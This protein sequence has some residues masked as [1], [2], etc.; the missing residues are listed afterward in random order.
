MDE[1]LLNDASRCREEDH[2][3]EE[4]RKSSRKETEKEASSNINGSKTEILQMWA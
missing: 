2:C 4:E 1:D 3:D